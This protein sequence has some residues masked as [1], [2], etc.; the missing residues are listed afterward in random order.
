MK[1]KIYSIETISTLDEH[2]IEHLDDHLDPHE[3]EHLYE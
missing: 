2:S 1:N 3:D